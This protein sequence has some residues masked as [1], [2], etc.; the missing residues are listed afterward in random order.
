MSRTVQCVLLKKEA[1]GLDKPPYPGELGK[2][3]F[4]NVS[5]EAWQQW[6]K[7]Q[8]MLINEYRLTPIGDTIEHSD[9]PDPAYFGESVAKWEGDTLVVDPVAHKPAIGQSRGRILHAR[10]DDLLRDRRQRRRHRHQRRV[11]RL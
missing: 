9:D 8:V 2:R 1:P 11:L 6:L 10:L 5:K 3:I 4:E 7:H